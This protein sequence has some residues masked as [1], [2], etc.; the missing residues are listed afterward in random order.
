M[1]GAVAGAAFQVVENV[2]EQGHTNGIDV[3]LKVSVPE[4]AEAD[5]NVPLIVSELGQAPP[6]VYENV[7]LLLIAIGGV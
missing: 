7:L 5:V 6:P 2:P 1:D 4:A 3:Y